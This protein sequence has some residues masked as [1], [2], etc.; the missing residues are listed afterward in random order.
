[1]AAAEGAKR[2][3]LIHRTLAVSNSDECASNSIEE[4]LK[5]EVGPPPIGS[6]TNHQVS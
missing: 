4:M 1:M 2:N 5:L 3:E 6:E